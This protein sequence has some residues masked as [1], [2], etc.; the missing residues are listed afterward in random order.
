MVGGVGVT[1]AVVADAGRLVRSP[2]R[3]TRSPATPP[4]GVRCDADLVVLARDRHGYAECVATVRS[5]YAQYDDAAFRLGRA[6]VLRDLLALPR[7]S[8]VARPAAAARQP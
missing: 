2:W 1:P 6:A 5:E 7:S 4:G 3:T 8:V